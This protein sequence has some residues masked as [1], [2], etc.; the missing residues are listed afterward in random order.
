MLVIRVELWPYGLEDAKTVL[1]EG[2]IAN[3][4]RHGSGY[5]YRAVLS[6]TGDPELGIERREQIVEISGYDRRQSVW[7][8][9]LQVLAKGR[10][11][12]ER[13]RARV[14]NEQSLTGSYR[15]QPASAPRVHEGKRPCS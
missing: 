3:R 4:G 7:N 15:R 14:R 13:T 1:A 8:L 6:E 12:Q 9:L 5:T 10:A 11:G 2:T